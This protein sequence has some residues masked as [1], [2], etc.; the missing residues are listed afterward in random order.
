MVIELILPLFTVFAATSRRLRDPLA[1][2]LMMAPLVVGVYGLEINPIIIQ[3]SS[4][5]SFNPVFTA[6]MP[7]VLGTVTTIVL[8]GVA[9]EQAWTGDPYG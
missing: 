8:L 7:E 2:G 1:F 3:L 6:S 9:L 5:L 4:R